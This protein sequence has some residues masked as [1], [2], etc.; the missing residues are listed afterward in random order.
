[1]CAVVEERFIVIEVVTGQPVT[2]TR[3]RPIVGGVPMLAQDART[4]DGAIVL[5]HDDGS[6]RTEDGREF[7]EIPE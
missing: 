5:K 1:M 3:I 7:R 4:P 6:Y 2:L